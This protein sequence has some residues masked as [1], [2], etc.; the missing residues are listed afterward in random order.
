[1]WVSKGQAAPPHL[2]G[3]THEALHQVVYGDVGGRAGQHPG[4]AAQVEI[5]SR[6]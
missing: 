5:E 6:T 4:E 2:G 3:D 1:M